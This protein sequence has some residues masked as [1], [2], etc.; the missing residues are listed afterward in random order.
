MMESPFPAAPRAGFYRLE[1]PARGVY[2]CLLI[3]AARKEMRGRYLRVVLLAD[4]ETVHNAFFDRFVHAM[5]IKYF[6]D[7]DT[8]YIEL[9]RDAVVETKD[10]DENTK[11]SKRRHHSHALTAARPLATLV[12]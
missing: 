7:T 6:K 5:K 8:L 2:R 9:R 1:R 10:L 12:A 4:G 11:G 3:G